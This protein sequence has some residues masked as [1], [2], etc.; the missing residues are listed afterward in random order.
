MC[1]TLGVEPNYHLLQYLYMKNALILHDT[2][3]D[4]TGNWFP[5]LK[6]QLKNKGYKVWVPDLPDADTPSTKRYNKFLLEENDWE[7]ND[8]SLIIGRSS[9]AVA[10]LGLLQ[11]LPLL[12]EL[13][14]LSK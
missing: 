2:G 12:I 9:G 3:N 1:D 4:H 7:F 13:L 14:E 11:E 5:W 6:T 10:I 8:E